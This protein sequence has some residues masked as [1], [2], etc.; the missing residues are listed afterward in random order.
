MVTRLEIQKIN[1]VLAGADRILLASHKNCGDATGSIIALFLILKQQGKQVTMFLPAPV[2]A[3]FVFLPYTEQI[4]TD[5][6]RIDL[7]KFDL[8]F[9]VDAAEIE[10]TGLAEKWRRRQADLVTIN[11]DHHLTNPSYGDLNI[12]HKDASAASILLYE[13]FKQDSLPVTREIA[14]CLLTGILTD[15]GTFSNPGTTIASLQAAAE[16]LLRGVRVSKVFEQ[17]VRNKTVNDLRLWGRALERLKVD[18]ELGLVTTV[19]TQKDIDELGVDAESLEGIAN[20]LNDLSGFKAVLVLKE[21]AD[22]TIKG[23]LRTTRE[24]V[25]VAELAKLFGGGGHKK[26]AGFMIG[27]YLVE[28]EIGWSILENKKDP[29]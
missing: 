6:K 2:S 16:M 27:G 12:V 17:L 3:T 24:D 20:F 29:G 1:K 19:I 5:S 8:F 21:Q 13:W 23:S 28:T 15:T 14:T 18:G 10:M 4:I 26:A 25:D 9:C 7:D 22:G 11:L